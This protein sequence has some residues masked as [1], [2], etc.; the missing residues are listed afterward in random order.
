MNRL[1]LVRAIISADRNICIDD[2]DQ[3]LSPEMFKL[4]FEN[5]SICRH[6]DFSAAEL[7]VREARHHHWLN[8]DLIMPTLDEDDAIKI[9]TDYLDE[10]FFR[11]SAAGVV[12]SFLRTRPMTRYA[13]TLCT[14]N[15]AS[16]TNDIR[17]V[18][19]NY[20]DMR[21]D[22]VTE[23]IHSSL[24]TVNIHMIQSLISHPDFDLVH[25]R[26]ALAERAYKEGNA[27]LAMIIAG[28][29][30]GFDVDDYINENDIQNMTVIAVA[31]NNVPL[32]NA[33][34]SATDD[35]GEI[36]SS[37]FKHGTAEMLE[38]FLA[39]PLTTEYELTLDGFF[40]QADL[41]PVLMRNV[42]DLLSVVSHVLVSNNAR[43]LQLV[44]PHL[45]LCDFDD[46]LDAYL[47]G[48]LEAAQI[49]LPHLAVDDDSLQEAV[50]DACRF[51]QTSRVALFL[52]HSPE[53]DYGYNDNA[54]LELAIDLNNF[55]L[56]MLLMQNERNNKRSYR[57][58]R[59][60]GN[61]GVSIYNVNVIANF[62]LN[63]VLS[64]IPSVIRFK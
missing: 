25:D 4:L 64:V 42:P 18:I 2:I 58:R 60:F 51:N 17:S 61:V 13:H 22:D 41:V 48:T 54:L 7:L 8:V 16:T 49:I 30:R 59:E 10:F 63:N 19:I 29:K 33:S 44:A 11:S 31:T 27:P 6:T 21:D 40:D 53:F 20:L 55:P 50:F 3:E 47:N 24:N 14:E 34:L 56:A 43:V 35:F 46:L 26:K 5:V 37:L 32:F 1:D 15:F 38:A 45:G 39:H 52:E 62:E 23:L 9:F 36:E 28:K 57:L 12:R